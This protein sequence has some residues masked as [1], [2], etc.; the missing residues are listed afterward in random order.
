MET[1][2]S[3]ES[4]AKASSTDF[5][6]ERSNHLCLLT[7]VRSC[8]P[9]VVD[10]EV[11]SEVFDVM[12]AVEMVEKYQPQSTTHNQPPTINHPQSTTHNQPPTINHPQSTTHSQPPTINHP[13][14]TTHN[15]PPTI[16]HPQS[17]THS[18]PSTPNTQLPTPHTQHLTPNAQPTTPTHSVI[19]CKASL[20][21]C[22]KKAII[23]ASEV[24]D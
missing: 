14:S 23:L 5:L 2:R 21:C 3:G 24:R 9:K 11:V 22:L 16:N 12:K 10:S 19:S 4:P 13:Q 7:F 1:M 6:R 20:K 8:E 15:Q 17:T 18:Q